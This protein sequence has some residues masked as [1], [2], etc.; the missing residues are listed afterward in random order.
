[1]NILVSYYYLMKLSGQEIEIEDTKRYY[2]ARAKEYD[3][4]AGYE[5][6][7]SEMFRKRMKT[8]F[9]KAFKGRNVLEIACGTGYWTQILASTASTV[10]A[11]DINEDMLRLA[12]C[13][14]KGIENVHFKKANAYTLD[15]VKGPF[16]GAFSHWWWSHVP[17][18]QLRTFLENL[19]NKLEPGALVLFSDHLVSNEPQ[20]WTNSRGDN[21]EERALENGRRF[22]IIK[23]CPSQ[24]EVKAVLKGIARNIRFKEYAEG[25]WIL[26]YYSV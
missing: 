15:G 3:R 8:Q 11:T 25:Y 5:N 22:R 17:K 7:I 4:T 21:L 1:L 16:N 19:H 18:A 24:Y 23:N 9:K 20:R 12:R 26:N 2:A 14:F 6:P 13:K 10:L